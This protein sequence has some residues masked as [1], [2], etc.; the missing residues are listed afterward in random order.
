MVITV[1]GIS[2][3][4]TQPCIG[5]TFVTLDEFTCMNS[6]ITDKEQEVVKDKLY[7]ETSC[8]G[9]HKRLHTQMFKTINPAP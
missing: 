9:G 8:Q 1:P 7:L 4:T 6:E 3:K 5:M 2:A